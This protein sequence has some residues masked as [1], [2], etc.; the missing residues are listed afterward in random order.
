VE[1]QPD[2][3][4]S[5]GKRALLKAGWVAPAIVVLAL[6]TS[7]YATNASRPNGRPRSRPPW[8]P[9]QPPWAGPPGWTPGPKR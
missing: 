1:Q 4:V 8:T 5:Q 9:G 2:P 6:P 7:S 3:G